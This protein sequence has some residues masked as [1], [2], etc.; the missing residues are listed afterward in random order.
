[1]SEQFSSWSCELFGG[2]DAGNE[3]P[4]RGAG[5]SP[6]EALQIDQSYVVDKRWTFR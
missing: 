2:V 5:L 4:A 3:G 6:Q 1:M